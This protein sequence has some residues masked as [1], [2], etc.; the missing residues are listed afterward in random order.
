MMKTVEIE[1]KK[2]ELDNK[3]KS[4]QAKKE[5]KKRDLEDLAKMGK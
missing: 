2:K 1:R 5:K 4:E 3:L